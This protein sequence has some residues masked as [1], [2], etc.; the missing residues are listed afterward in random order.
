LFI[1]GGFIGEWDGDVDVDESG[2]EGEAEPL[3]II[4]GEG[5]L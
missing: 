1:P 3:W 2:E 5:E 4:I